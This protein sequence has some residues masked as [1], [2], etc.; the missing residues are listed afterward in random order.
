MGPELGVQCLTNAEDSPPIQLGRRARLVR[1]CQS[2][3]A[4][5]CNALH[6]QHCKTS[7]FH[8]LTSGAFS[9]GDFGSCSFI[10][11]RNR[12]RLVQ[13]SAKTSGELE[14]WDVNAGSVPQ[15]KQALPDTVAPPLNNTALQACPCWVAVQHT[16]CCKDSKAKLLFAVPREKYSAD[17]ACGIGQRIGPGC[18][19]YLLEEKD[20]AL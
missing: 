7:L 3:P 8:E 9:P 19:H 17:L 14:S 6:F 1:G 10:F 16:S 5:N 12:G 2:T 18:F 15:S 11:I 20:L 13:L 4:A